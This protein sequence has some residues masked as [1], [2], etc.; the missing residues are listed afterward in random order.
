M[1]KEKVR[2]IV[3]EFV[4]ISDK[5]TIKDFLTKALVGQVESDDLVKLMINK[6]ENNGITINANTSKAFRL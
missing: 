6:I 2:I 1:T 3:E 4:K 5:E